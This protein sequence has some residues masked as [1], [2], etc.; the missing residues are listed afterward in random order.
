[1]RYFFDVVVVSVVAMVLTLMVMDNSYRMTQI[2][3]SISENREG[4]AS[5]YGQHPRRG[6]G[7]PVVNAMPVFRVKPDL[8]PLRWWEIDELCWVAVVMM[9]SGNLKKLHALLGKQIAKLKDCHKRPD[10]LG[11][12]TRMAKAIDAYLKKIVKEHGG[13]LIDRNWNKSSH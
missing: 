7:G 6:L 8:Q 9:Y 3:K 4:V 13:P 12:Q 2:E 1:M 10:C 11:K 5:L